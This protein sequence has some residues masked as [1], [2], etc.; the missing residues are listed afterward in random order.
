MRRE[1]EKKEE[2]KR[3]NYPARPDHLCALASLFSA[4]NGDEG[5]REKKKKENQFTGKKRKIRD[6]AGP[7]GNFWI[8]RLERLLLVGAGVKS[9]FEKK[10]RKEKRKQV[11]EKRGG[12]WG[13]G[14]RG[15]GMVACVPPSKITDFLL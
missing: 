1:K 3:K 10:K 13:R 11:E 4:V 7:L 15:T 2:K 6:R 8:L 14:G 12:G 9:E 5:G